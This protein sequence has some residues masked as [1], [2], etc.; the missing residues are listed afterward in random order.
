MSSASSHDDAADAGLAPPARFAGPQVNAVLELEKAADSIGIHVIGDRRP[1]HPDG[2][3]ENLAQGDTQPFELRAGEPA[4]STARP[5]TGM[6][7]ALIRIN[8]AYA[9]QKPLIEQ[10]GLDGQPAA[11][12]KRGELVG[13]DG[14]RIRSWS[15]K[16]LL[17]FQIAE[18]QPAKAPG[19]DKPKFPAA[20]QAQ[21]R[22]RM[23][24]QGRVRL[25]DEQ[26]AAHA[27]MNNPLRFGPLCTASLP[28]ARRTQLADNVFSGAVDSENAA[29]RKPFSLPR[30]RRLEGLGVPAEPRLHNTVATHPF[31]DAAGNGFHLGQ[32]RH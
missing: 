23:R 7:Q 32:L 21:P 28:F 15:G 8:I 3:M 10:C 31:V 18:F 26:P 24:C 16:G 4:G 12:K 14:E 11:A 6:E 22:V 29:P 20:G 27:K 19:I 1:A 5:D 13:A 25:G 17:S 2:V 30:R 9:G